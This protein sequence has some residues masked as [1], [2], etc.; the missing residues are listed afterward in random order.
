MPKTILKTWQLLPD[1]SEGI[2]DADVPG[3]ATLLRGT[4]QA[5]SSR[6]LPA[7]NSFSFSEG[8]DVRST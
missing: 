4:C 8:D 2:C 1:G 3:A 7:G 5:Y 6:A